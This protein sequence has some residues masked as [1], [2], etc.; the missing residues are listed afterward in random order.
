[1][2]DVVLLIAQE[3]M[4]QIANQM[5]MKPVANSRYYVADLETLTHQGAIS[6]S[7]SSIA[8]TSPDAEYPIFLNHLTA[9]QFF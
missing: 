6:S 4:Q 8:I 9:P 3:L 2:N 5:T 1:M 7:Y